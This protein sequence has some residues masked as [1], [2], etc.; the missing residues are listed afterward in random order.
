ML[1]K[2]AVCSFTLATVFVVVSF[3]KAMPHERTVDIWLPQ[4]HEFFNDVRSKSGELRR[5]RVLD[6]SFSGTAV[7]VPFNDFRA[8]LGDF[9]NTIIA[10]DDGTLYYLVKEDARVYVSTVVNEK[11][12]EV[13]PT[14]V[15]IRGNRML[16]SFR[17]NASLFI[18]G[19]ALAIAFSA[20]GGLSLGVWHAR[21]DAA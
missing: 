20:G 3:L 18:T 17:W 4:D 14:N 7:F 19:V 2:L 15:N 13:A 21:R 11:W 9:H 16:L 1:K 6:A 12:W 8:Q 5:V 10:R